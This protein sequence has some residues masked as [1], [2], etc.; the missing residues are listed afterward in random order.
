MKLRKATTDDYDSITSL[1]Q[2]L[3]PED[4][5]LEESKGRGVFNRIIAS[6]DNNE[7]LYR[8]G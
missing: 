1:Y 4:P 7:E 3:L 2:Q 8:T 6:E 5:V